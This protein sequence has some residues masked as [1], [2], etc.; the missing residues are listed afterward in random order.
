M[1]LTFSVQGYIEQEIEITNRKYTEKKV[2]SL[3]NRG[4]AATTIQEGGRVVFYTKEGKEVILGKVVN[5][6]NNLEYFDFD[7]DSDN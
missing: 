6:D 5:V 1:K 3:L 7:S 2:L 4:L